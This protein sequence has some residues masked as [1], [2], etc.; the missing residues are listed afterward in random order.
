MSNNQLSLLIGISMVVSGCCI[1]YIAQKTMF[2][3]FRKSIRNTMDMRLK[4]ER[5]RESS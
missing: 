3:Q 2:E 1:A 5:K 4:A